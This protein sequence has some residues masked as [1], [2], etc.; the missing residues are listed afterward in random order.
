M[1]FHGLI[2]IKIRALNFPFIVEPNLIIIAFAESKENFIN[3]RAQRSF[4]CG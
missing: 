1:K 3:G 4:E 2:A